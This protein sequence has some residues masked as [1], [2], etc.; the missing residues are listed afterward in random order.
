MMSSVT[1]QHYRDHGRAT[2][3]FG[4]QP[5]WKELACVRIMCRV[6]YWLVSFALQFGLKLAPAAFGSTEIHAS[7]LVAVACLPG[8]W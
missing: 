2:S 1:D 6:L 7:V 3:D 5:K 8:T 4:L